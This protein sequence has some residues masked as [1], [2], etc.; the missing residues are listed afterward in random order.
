MSEN[1]NN[2]M[3]TSELQSMLKAAAATL[4]ER[5]TAGDEEAAEALQDSTS[6]VEYLYGGLSV[7]GIIHYRTTQSDSVTRAGT[8]NPG[9]AASIYSTSFQGWR[10]GPLTAAGKV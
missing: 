8:S 7:R 9:A 4:Q 10:R 1:A 6:E 2:E 3:S 5:A